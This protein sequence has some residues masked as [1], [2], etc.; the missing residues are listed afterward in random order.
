MNLEIEV[1]AGRGVLVGEVCSGDGG[2]KDFIAFF[3][4]FE[5][6]GD[7]IPPPYEGLSQSSRGA[8]KYI[9]GAVDFSPVS[10]TI[11]LAAPPAARRLVV[12]FASWQCK[13]S[14]VFRD[15]PRISGAMVMSRVAKTTSDKIRVVD[16]SPF[17]AGAVADIELEVIRG[18]NDGEKAYIIGVRQFDKDGN[19]IEGRQRGLSY[20]EAV[21]AYRYVDFTTTDLMVPIRLSFARLSMAERYEVRVQA[22]RSGN[23]PN[24]KVVSRSY[25]ADA[26]TQLA[27]S[28]SLLDDFI[29]TTYE[30][31]P[32]GLVLITATTK[33]I[34]SE[35]R[36]NRPQIAAKT[37]AQ[38]GYRVVYV[39]FRFNAD[40]ELCEQAIDNILQLPID[41]FASLYSRLAVVQIAAPR[42]AI[43]SIPDDVAC[44]TIGLFQD[45]GWRTVYEVRDDWEEFA[46]AGVGK[47]YRPVFERF[48]ARTAD[49]VACVSPALVSK[50]EQFSGSAT[51]V[52]LSPNATTPAFI[53]AG[54]KYRKRRSRSAGSVNKPVIGYF[55]HLTDAW[56]DF[57]LLVAAALAEPDW[58]FELIGFGAPKREFPQN[59]RLIDAVP[60]LELPAMTEKWDVGIIPFRQTALS[61]AVDPIK[62]YDYLSLNL[63]VV[64]VEM[65]RLAEMAGCYIYSDLNSFLSCCR[66][67]L[68]DYANKRISIPFDARR[69]TWNYRL[70]AFLAEILEDPKRPARKIA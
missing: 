36:L 29:D 9:R 70:E 38:A 26:A 16:D 1:S 34:D 67:A 20:S 18:F 60:P 11:P 39:Y 45:H 7:L 53:E 64:S 2:P 50:M 28:E 55:G 3:S 56:F 23:I 49:R 62:V 10:F 59:I 40:E 24:A 47:W 61:R 33:A 63:P 37:F 69:N 4:F 41:M 54:A 68:H 57:G 43:F 66:A 46:A 5:E 21:G 12:S 44:R 42:I 31:E 19:I 58:R 8:Y 25:R 27:Q 6:N 17:P 22:W 65:G 52:F 51:S 32:R 48:L 15:R 30:Q 13:K 14:P 35:N